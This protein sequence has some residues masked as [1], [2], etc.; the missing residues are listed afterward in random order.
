MTYRRLF[1]RLVPAVAALLLT[2]TV[3]A[4]E[5]PAR[6]GPAEN[7]IV[8]D[9]YT[10]D[11]ATLVVDGTAYVF[12]GRDEAAPGQQAFVMREWH[13]FS[14][15]S[16]S[17]DPAA[18]QHH[19]AVLSLD[20]FAWAG[21]NAW[22][23]EVVQGPDGRF[24]WFVSVD[25]RTDGG[26]MNIG[27]AVADHPLG[28]YRDALGGP[29]ISDA[30]PGSSALNIDPTVF[31][32]DGEV[33]LYWGSYWEPRAVRL[34]DSMTALDGAVFEPA[35]LTGFWEAPWLFE[36]GGVY[37]LAYASNSG[38]DCVTDSAY[39]CIRYATAGSP[40]GP[41]TH[42]GVVLGQVSSTT[43]HPA[44]MEF[45]D[46]WHMVYHTAGAPG[47]GNFRRSVAIDDLFFNPDGTMRKVV[48][49]P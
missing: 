30:T 2:T 21:A 1:A 43:N 7:P 11:P 41:W 34:Q 49:T 35:G 10:A 32:D 24:Y 26:W 9:I 40:A 3:A 25:G 6:T 4:A 13:A 18:W 14:S 20:T 44:I 39:A 12:T 23:S 8:T 38:A 19:G 31:L 15:R 17:N 46:R 29:L 33:Y 45:G 27:V 42:R 36:R 47:G 22:A 28:P 37:Y 48:Q 5:T 16:P